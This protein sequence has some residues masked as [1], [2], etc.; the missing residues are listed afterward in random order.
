VCWWISGSARSVAVWKM[1]PLCM[2]G[3]L[4]RKMNDISFEDHERAFT[5]EEV[6]TLFLYTLYV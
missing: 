2:L 3:C 4:W 5:F 1:M 6:K